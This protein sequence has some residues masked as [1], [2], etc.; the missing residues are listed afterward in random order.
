MQ[1]PIDDKCSKCMYT[2]ANR[3]LIK[4]LSIVETALKDSQKSVTWLLFAVI[5]LVFWSTVIKAIF[6]E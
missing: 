4:R 2:E 1:S 3:D 5:L 6:C